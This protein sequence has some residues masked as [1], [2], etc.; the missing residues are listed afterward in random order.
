MGVLEDCAPTLAAAGLAIPSVINA[1]AA[2]A[3][4]I[5]RRRLG[6]FRKVSTET[7]QQA[8]TGGS[9]SPDGIRLDPQLSTVMDTRFA[10]QRIFTAQISPTA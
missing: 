7:F 8:R 1:A 5:R 6:T 9:L 4:T 2:K 3:V 10:R